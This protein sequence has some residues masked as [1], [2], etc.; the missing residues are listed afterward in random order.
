[1][2][3]NYFKLKCKYVI[4]VH[5]FIDSNGVT[6]ESKQLLIVFNYKNDIS[7]KVFY[8]QFIVKLFRLVN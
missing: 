5:W 6:S 4:Y 8:S 3:I 2:R 1:M 7:K